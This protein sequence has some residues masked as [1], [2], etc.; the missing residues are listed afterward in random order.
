MLAVAIAAFALSGAIT[1][2]L[3]Y[4][5]TLLSKERETSKGLVLDRDTW[6]DKAH[7][8]EV[9]LLDFKTEQ[10]ETI[11]ALDSQILSFKQEQAA[12][13]VAEKQR[14][15]L[16]EEMAKSSDPRGVAANIRNQLRKLAEM[17]RPATPAGQSS[18]KEGAVHGPAT[19]PTASKL[20]R[21]TG[22]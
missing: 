8:Q 22:K 12:R 15:E 3:V 21:G 14:D 9:R 1:G 16:L 10:N 5:L 19:S 2:A 4:V 17:S 20:P 11:K 18:A 13:L 6:K 7:E